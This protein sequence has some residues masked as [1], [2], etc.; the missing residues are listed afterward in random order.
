M[1]KRTLSGGKVSAD[2]R[3]GLGY[4]ELMLTY[5]LSTA[6]LDVVFKQLSAAGYINEADVLSPGEDLAH[7]TN[8]RSDE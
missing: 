4:N 6:A 2:I 7:N 3:A 1:P 8:A 5:G